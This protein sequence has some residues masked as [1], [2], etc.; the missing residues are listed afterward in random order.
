VK[1]CKFAPKD[2]LFFLRKLAFY[3]HKAHKRAAS[4][5]ELV[6]I[7]LS[8]I[9]GVTNKAAAIIFI[10][11]IIKI[12]NLLFQDKDGAWNL[13]HLQFQ[14]YLAAVEAKDNHDIDLGLYL[15]DGWWDLVIQF[16]AAITR[17]ISSLILRSYKFHGD[18]LS[19][20][21]LILSRLLMLV[22]LAP[23]TNR[24]LRGVIEREA[25]L[26][27]SINKSNPSTASLL[28]SSQWYNEPD[29]VYT[30]EGE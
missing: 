15:D 30:W 20:N 18:C 25:E 21:V 11:E 14:E 16:Y 10:N 8:H 19:G 9:G 29:E 24:K 26:I 5:N 13:G 7:T 6:E 23:N 28:S 22:K 27:D 17:D 2:K 4:F 12:N 3:L 1:R